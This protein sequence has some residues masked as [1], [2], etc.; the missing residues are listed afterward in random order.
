MNP[1]TRGMAAPVETGLEGDGEADDGADET[2]LPE[3]V[4][5]DESSPDE[6]VGE[7]EVSGRFSQPPRMVMVIML[8]STSVMVVARSVNS[9]EVGM[10]WS[11]PDDMLVWMDPS[12]TAVLS[13]IAPSACASL[14][15]SRYG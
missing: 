12:Q 15:I 8:A 3:G 10:G 4:E 1:V 13:S 11:V 9:V 7:A 5:D 2:S 6:G 14:F